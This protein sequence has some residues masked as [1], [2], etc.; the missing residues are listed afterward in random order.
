MKCLTSS[1]VSSSLRENYR[2]RGVQQK[3]RQLQ[4]YCQQAGMGNIN[5][6]NRF[7]STMFLARLS[8]RHVPHFAS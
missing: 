3:F 2:I 6:V 5:D 1:P 4:I 7:L 8:L